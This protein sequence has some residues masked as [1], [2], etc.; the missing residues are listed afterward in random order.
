MVAVLQDQF[1]QLLV[2]PGRMTIPANRKETMLMGKKG[3]QPGEK[4]PLKLTAPERKLVLEDLM[5]LDKA[6]EQVCLL[7]T[8]PSPRDRS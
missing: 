7:Y 5:C 1:Y 8:S 4:V 3:I 6:Y 2:E